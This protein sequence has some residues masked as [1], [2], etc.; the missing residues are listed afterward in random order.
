M[1]IKVFSGVFAF[2]LLATAGFGVN[3]SLNSDANLSDLALQNVLA[4]ADVENPDPG[5]GGTTVDYCY[6]EGSFGGTQSY[7]VFCDSK[8]DDKKI[9]PC[10]SSTF[11]VYLKSARDRC[12]KPSE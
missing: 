8:T 9:F 2:A 6:I 1:R 3:K 12:T 11:G 10:A 4:L 5:E 7:E